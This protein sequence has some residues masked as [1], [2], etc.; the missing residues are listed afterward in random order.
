MSEICYP[1]IHEFAPCVH[2]NKIPKVSYEVHSTC[3][4]P[5]NGKSIH[6]TKGIS[7]KDPA[8]IPTGRLRFSHT[9]SEFTSVN[10]Y[11]DKPF[12][13]FFM[14]HDLPEYC[15]LLWDRINVK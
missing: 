6:C 8:Y 9:C 5:V 4:S 3:I 12:N 14:I 13:R 1:E 15:K 10:T 11:H 7:S 2:C